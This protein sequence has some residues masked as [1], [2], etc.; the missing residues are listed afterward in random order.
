MKLLLLITFI[1]V[2]NA[3]AQVRSGCVTKPAKVAALISEAQA[4][5]IEIDKAD[6][7]SDPAIRKFPFCWHGCAVSLVKPQ[8]AAWLNTGRQHDLV[9]VRAVSNEEGKVIGV[10]ILSGPKLLRR[11]AL[12][13]ACNSEFKPVIFSGKPVKFLWDITY[14]FVN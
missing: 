12:A 8:K 9:K 13:A 6:R 2:T 3:A 4:V 11:P 5:K 10:K 1:F 7:I 14:N